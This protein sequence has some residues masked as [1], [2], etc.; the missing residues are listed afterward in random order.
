MRKSFKL[1][2][3]LRGLNNGDWSAFLKTVL[4]LIPTPFK[5]SHWFHWDRNSI[6]RL[7]LY[8]NIY[9]MVLAIFLGVN[10]TA[11]PSLSLS[12]LYSSLVIHGFSCTFSYSRV[13]TKTHLFTT[14]ALNLFIPIKQLKVPDA[15]E[16][17]Q[18]IFKALMVK[19][20]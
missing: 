3:I 5:L 19:K 15:A 2:I 8:P 1:L 7:D 17:M 12:Y 6:C 18:N 9:L 10:I 20:N 4:P 13:T 16:C 14:V 11:D